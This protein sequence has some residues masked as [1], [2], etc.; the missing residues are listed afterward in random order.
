MSSNKNAGSA[1]NNHAASS[2]F[3]NLF[4]SQ[5]DRQQFKNEFQTK[6]KELWNSMPFF[7]RLVSLTLIN[8]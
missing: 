6:S 7:V 4:S 5:F 2:D 8:L 3:A 1:S